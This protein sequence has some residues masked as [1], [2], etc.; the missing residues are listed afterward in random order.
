MKALTLWQPWASMVALGYKTFETRSWSTEY[1]GQLAIHAAQKTPKEELLKWID[2]PRMADL[3]TFNG[4]TLDTLPTG[5]IVATV[6]L[7]EVYPTE[8]VL[9]L[10]DDENRMLGDYS[11]GRFAWQLTNLWTLPEPIPARGGQRLW[12]WSDPVDWF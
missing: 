2:N 8:R 5:V 9:Y 10:I 6:S 7:A 12:E 4:F 3:L 1:R 11:P